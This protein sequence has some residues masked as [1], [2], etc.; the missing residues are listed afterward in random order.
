METFTGSYENFKVLYSGSIYAETIFTEPYPRAT[1]SSVL[2]LAFLKLVE[3][4]AYN[5]VSKYVK[6]T[7]GYNLLLPSKSTISITLCKAIPLFYPIGSPVPKKDIFDKIE[8]IV[9]SYAEKY[10][11]AVIKGLF[12]RL[13]YECDKDVP[14]STEFPKISD[15]DMIRKIINVMVYDQGGGELPD[16]KSLRNKESRYPTQVTKLKRK[17]KECGP[18]IV[19]DME[20]LLVNDVHIPYAA[21]FLVVKPG[22]DLASIPSDS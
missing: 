14:I 13:Y 17:R 3:Q 11:D 7:I 8:Q 19:A 9:N 15:K 1:D 5:I 4:Y 22:N 21:G 10:Q 18:F 2:T 16:V 6:F 20:T 12:I